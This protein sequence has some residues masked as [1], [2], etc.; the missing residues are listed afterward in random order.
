MY[1]FR[2]N[3]LIDAVLYSKHRIRSWFNYR[4][5]LRK[6]KKSTPDYKMLITIYEFIDQ[7]NFAYFHVLSDTDHLFI[8]DSRKSK[9]DESVKSLL[10]KDT[11]VEIILFLKEYSTITLHIKRGMGYA[12]TSITFSDGQAVL[13][14]E[15]EEQLFINCTNLI[16]NEL[17]RMI[18]KYRKFGRL[19]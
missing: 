8:R 2:H 7:L 4:R 14:N 1:D 10:Y 5:L 6:I 3:E 17:Y 11:G 12:Q 13:N 9:K 15:L 18:K 19:K 16:M